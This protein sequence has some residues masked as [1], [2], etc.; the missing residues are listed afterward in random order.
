MNQTRAALAGYVDAA[1]FLSANRYFVSFMSGN[2]T[3]L[4]VALGTSPHDAIVPAL[5]IGGFI[6]GVTAGAAAA[7]TWS[8][9]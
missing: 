7:S 6:A 4:G 5:L 3:R 9:T 2:T 8:P 1:G